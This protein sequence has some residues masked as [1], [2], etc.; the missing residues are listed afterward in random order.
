MAKYYLSPGR[1][2]I[3]DLRLE[4]TSP[5]THLFRRWKHFMFYLRSWQV[6]GLGRY[7]HPIEYLGQHHRP[8][9]AHRG[10]SELKGYYLC[11]SL[12]E[13]VA[14]DNS[15]QYLEMRGW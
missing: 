11:S 14:I 12:S 1:S 5:A 8:E 9:P 7:M 3:C 2:M 10:I 6:F 15:N 13:N 4:R